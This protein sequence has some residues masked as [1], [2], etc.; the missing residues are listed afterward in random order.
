MKQFFTWFYY[1]SKRQLKNIFFILVLLLI[2]VSALILKSY[3]SSLTVSL[4]IGV[5]DLDKTMLSKELVLSLNTTDKNSVVV[6]TVYD[7]IET[8]DKD[9][10]AGKIQ[11]GYSILPGFEAKVSQNSLKGLIDVH[12]KPDSSIVLLSNELFFTYVFKEA[13]YYTLTK[14][15]EN[16]NIFYNISDEYYEQ[17]RA[18]YTQYLEAGRTFHFNYSQTDGTYISS[19]NIDILDFIKTPVRGVV[20]VF[21]FISGLAGGF[22]F[23]KDSKNKITNK[24]CIFDIGIP[25]FFSAVS[26]L[27]SIFIIG[28]NK[29]I[30]KETVITACYC[31]IVI[32]FVFL[33][34]RLVKNNISYCSTIPVFSLGSIICCPIFINL[35]TFLPIINILQYLFMPTYYFM[36]LDI[37]K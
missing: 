4:S 26:G 24:L 16:S 32:L 30:L 37:I 1:L 5:I 7:D 3:S 15:M 18:G 8:M 21:I 19:N 35:K 14:D 6:F 33:L 25:V 34:T 28:I 17:L 27:I 31:T 36:L 9:I 20:A 13:G 10:L 2:P 29:G 23:L 12:S 22:T 11:C